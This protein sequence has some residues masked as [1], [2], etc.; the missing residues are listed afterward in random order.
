MLPDIVSLHLFASVAELRSITRAAEAQHLALA[1]ASRRISALE[2]NLGVRLLE[3]NARGAE[4]TAAGRAALHHVRRIL[5][6]V[7][8][9]RRELGEH[10]VGD[11]GHVRI[12]ASQSAVAQFLADDLASF[13]RE[14]PNVV[15]ALEEMASGEIA[16]GLREG[17]TDV[18]VVMDGTAL[19]GLQRFDYAV[20]RLVAL[21]P[22]EHSLRGRSVPFSAVLDYD[23]VGLD[24]GT[25]LTRLLVDQAAVARRPLRLRVQVRS[26]AALIR[27][28]EAGLGIGILPEG[29]ARS[30]LP[31][32]KVRIVRL[33]DSWAARRM[34]VCV[35]DYD[36]L[37][38]IARRLVDHLTH[39]NNS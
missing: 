11:R 18:G 25:A 7:E 16:Q 3:R 30:V 6:Q 22:R 26:F 32:L 4:L 20:D 38:A 8:E 10:A 33:S 1:A 15:I 9:M 23:V 21:V 37:P 24:S 17:A 12:H 13:A 35:R 39:R 27:M 36:L 29:A 14:V 19:E 5:G 31:A 34:F 28:V 2:E